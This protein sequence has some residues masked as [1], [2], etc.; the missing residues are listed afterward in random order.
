MTTSPSLDNSSSEQ[1][2]GSTGRR[3]FWTI[4]PLAIFAGVAGVFIIALLFGDPKNIPSVMVGKPVPVF[5]LPAIANV[6]GP[7]GQPAPGFD[8]NALKRGKITILNVWAT[9]CASCRDEH[10]MLMTLNKRAGVQVFGIDYKDNAG[11]ARR[12]LQRHGNPYNA[13]GEDKTGRVAIDFG[14][15][16]VPE[17]FIIDGNGVILLRHPGPVTEDVL[18]A[19]ILPVIAKARADAKQRGAQA[20]QNAGG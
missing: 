5:S 1:L 7:D 2:P 17:T 11:E 4:L 16:G 8:Q 18:T 15:Y 12:Y 14:V 6:T 19:M 20:V 3:R 9:W 10:P 13:L